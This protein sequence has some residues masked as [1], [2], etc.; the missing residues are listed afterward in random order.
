MLKKNRGE[1]GAADA[2]VLRLGLGGLLVFSVTLVAAGALIT[3]GVMSFHAG[4]GNHPVPETSGEPGSE[5]HLA[6]KDLPPWGELLTSEIEVERPE[7]YA[8]AELGL[9][10]G[11]GW[12]FEH[13]A[14]EQ[15]RPL[16]GACGLSREQIARALSPAL[17]SLTSTGT[18][19]RPDEPLLFS[20]APE[21]RVRLYHD[22]ARWPVNHYM[23]YPFCFRGSNITDPFKEIGLGAEVISKFQ[24]LSYRRGDTTYFSDYE[25]VLQSL[26]SE[27]ERLAFVKA[28]SRQRGLLVRVRIRQDTDIDKILSYWGRGLQT[29][30]A[31]PLLESIKRL[32]DGG[33]MSL[34]YLLPHFAR[35]RL[36][37][38]PL[39]PR[40][41]EPGIDCHW[42]TMNF[43]NE[44]PDDRFAEPTF[45]VNWLMTNYYPVAKANLYGDVVLFLNQDGNAIHSGVY[46]ADDIIFTK[47]GNNHMQPWMLMR[48]KDVLAMYSWANAATLAVYRDKR[49]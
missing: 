18:V 20:L 44:P 24:R 47:N 31:R 4:A 21:A 34:L 40:P 15:V 19:V 39:P 11:P 12:V 35:E 8:A 9:T 22:L 14:P 7:E 26:H 28:L 37:T 43:F 30:D 48:I 41:G 16:L 1:Q 49:W 6:P 46:L 2:F 10:N 33:T 38:F 23:T 5:P 13:L 45:T 32:Q 3:A 27:P 36:Y 17:M 29:K 42:S 25:T